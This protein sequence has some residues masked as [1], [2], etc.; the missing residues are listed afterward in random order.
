MSGQRAASRL[1]IVSPLAAAALALV[2]GAAH[3]DDWATLGLDGG[4]SRL[5]A[6][7]SGA[8]FAA[9]RWSFAPG[10]A[11]AV[12][13]PV[14]A[15]GFAASV[16]LDG[17]LSVL[18]ADTG[19]LVWQ[20]NA[21]I[22]VQGTPAV[23]HGRV[24]VP[25]LGGKLVAFALVDGTPLWT[26]EL[27]GMTI[28]SPAP[29]G[30]DIVVSAGFPQHRVVR[31]DGATGA[32]VWESPEVIDQPGNSSP[33]VG[34]GL[35]VV[36][37]N[38]GHVYA[39]DA[40]TGLSRWDYRADGVVHL[41]S[42]LIIGGRVYLAGGDDSD[43]VHAIDLPTGAALPG[44][45]A[46]LPAAD[47]DLAGAVLSR[48][49]AVSSFVAA[50]G[51]LILQTRLDDILDTDGDGVADHYLSREAVLGLDPA[52][53][54]T[55]WQVAL[56]RVIFTDPNDVPKFF[57][58]PTPAAFGTDGGT[59]LLA[60]A[61]SLAGKASLLDPTSGT[62]RG[63]LTLAGRALASPVFANGRLITV[64]ENGTVEGQLS[65][66]NRPPSAP[67]LAPNPRALDAS[68]VTLRWLPAVDP[69]AEIPTYELRI[70]SDGEV[71]QTFGQQIFP[72]QG[73]TSV[74]VVAPLAAGVTYTVA[75]RA[76]DPH[77]AYSP[78]SAPET[79]TVATPGAVTINGAPAANLRTAIANAVAGDIIALGAGTYPISETMHVGAGVSLQGVGAGRTVID[80]T[81]LSVGISFGAA[82]P[83]G[84]LG[85]DKTTVFGAD[86]CVAVAGGASAVR[87]TH[88]V[89]RDC[90]TVG[91]AVASGASAA[92]VNATLVGNGTAVDSGGSATIE[93]SILTGNGVALAGDSAGALTSSYD[94]LFGN[95]TDH[96]GLTA[97]TGDLAAEVAFVDLAGRNLL[98][99]GP[100]PST[101][102][103][104]PAD[105]VGAEPAPNGGRINLGA[106]G[107]T[108][109]A[110]TSAPATGGA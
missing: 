27:G 56:G 80:A 54:A 57:V 76:R 14:V 87:L 49:R 59:P 41:A 98:I 101:D 109:D 61:S 68:D 94:D 63:D 88:L 86:T 16:N 10:G 53:G 70:D 11:H 1:R 36:G 99:A 65:S 20:A 106:F 102:Q 110:E 23:A 89:V 40:A 17:T 77:G 64:A 21:G 104:D 2:S 5:S 7:R 74:S 6:E 75:A 29:V 19:A 37:S 62:D 4:R 84:S 82:D 48:H 25:T 26:A 95:Q 60:V 90:A 31:L 91:I 100:Q 67:I 15:D 58:C 97:G 79:F 103:G 33:A 107:G 51:R 8:R 42:P 3:A 13:S 96:R 55:L 52:T 47:P 22:V 34:G 44:W 72:A 50:G 35:V 9:G 18:A 39:F 93:N 32:V 43:R 85:L 66:V 105:D 24:F 92:I 108:A 69:D 45:P 71:L 81:G 38:G 12:S 30:T 46:G 28:S 73:A 83:K 78:W